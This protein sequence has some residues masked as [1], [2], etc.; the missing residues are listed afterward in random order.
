MTG[1][2]IRTAFK[3]SA[4]SNFSSSP[5]SI[6]PAIRKLTKLELIDQN[7]EPGEPLVIT[8]KGKEELRRWLT[9]NISMRDISKNSQILILKFAF[10]DHSVTQE[11]K[12]LFLRTLV[13][14]T[15]EYLTSLEEFIK[16]EG[17]AMPLHGRLALQH[18]IISFKA[19]LNWGKS[20]MK[21]IQ[22]AN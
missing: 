7:D 20:A 16:K 5:G 11:E 14:L 9:E 19:Q 15:R 13:N 22:N 3:T 12:E 18:G 1:Y 10:M 8:N 4:I 21:I 6:Y 17:A 2:G